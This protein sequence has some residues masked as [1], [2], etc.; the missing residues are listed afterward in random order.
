MAT[1]DFKFSPSDYAPAN[2]SGRALAVEFIAHA[3]K[4]AALMSA[5][6]KSD[7]AIRQARTDGDALGWAGDAVL[8]LD[9]YLLSHLSDGSGALR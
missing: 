2:S 3:M 9:A 5:G 6:W 7:D 8:F 4:A 1:A